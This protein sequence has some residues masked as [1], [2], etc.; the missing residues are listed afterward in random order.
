MHTTPRFLVSGSYD[1][2]TACMAKRQLD[3]PSALLSDYGAGAPRKRCSSRDFD[4]SLARQLGSLS[5]MPDAF[6]FT[7]MSAKPASDAIRGYFDAVDAPIPLLASMKIK[8]RAVTPK[9]R[10]EPEYHFLRD[11]VQ[12]L[13]SVVVVDQCVD[14]GATVKYAAELL[15][16]MGVPK[17]SVIRGSWYMTATGV[18]SEEL[19]STH[20][21]FMYGVGQTIAKQT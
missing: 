1:A 17:V 6:V 3:L 20:A 13:E 19:T 10:F 8:Q 5:T 2:I 12:G 7:E 21:D 11:E 9:T 18:S 15:L 4:T 14:S 16:T